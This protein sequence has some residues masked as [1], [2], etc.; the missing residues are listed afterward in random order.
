MDFWFV[1]LRGEED[2]LV[3]A[4]AV[5]GSPVAWFDTLHLY[6]F[7]AVDPRNAAS[8]VA[9]L[10]PVQG[11]AG[12]VVLSDQDP[13]AARERAISL[14]C[15]AGDG[16]LLFDGLARGRFDTELL[17]VRARGRKG[18]TLPVPAVA[19]APEKCRRTECRD[20]VAR[21]PV[22]VPLV[23]RARE[24]A[25]LAQ[26]L[27]SPAPVWLRAVEGSGAAR[28]VAEAARAAEKLVARVPERAMASEALLEAAIADAVGDW[29]YLDPVV[30]AHVDVVAAVASR[31]TRMRRLIL[32]SPPG[33]ELAFVPENRRM[34]L[35]R[36]KDFDAR[37]L[38][39][40]LLGDAAG[41][42]WSRRVARLGRGYPGRVIEAARAAVQLGEVVWDGERFRGRKVRVL[43]AR[44]A[45][46]EPL[47][48]RMQDVPARAMRALS[49]LATLGDGAP[50]LAGSAALRG[51][52]TSRPEELLGL[53][54]ALRLIEVRDAR[55]WIHASVRRMLPVSDP[56]ADTLL[57]KGVLP[58]AAE[59]EHL[60]SQGKVRD[61]GSLFVEAA[62][63]ALEAGLRAAAVRFIA[64]ALPHGGHEAVLSE[65]LLGAARSITRALGLAVVIEP[66]GGRSAGAMD[67]ATLEQAAAQCSERHD[68]AGAERLRVLAEVMRGNTQSALR[69]TGRHS[70]GGSSK[71]QL[72]AA[73]AQA[74]AGEMR[75]GIRTALS[76][77]SMSRKASD[78]GGEAAALA[79]LSSLYKACGRDDDARA[80]ADGARALQHAG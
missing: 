44:G 59:A 35:E 61:A 39:R 72:V 45:S 30:P 25:A 40:F 1:A 15:A 20:A 21:I 23:A 53:L 76:A 48:R 80:L 19:L 14:A 33:V 55:L 8:W 73:I 54:T 18:W 60:L 28:L 2:A 69:I 29:I 38:A 4:R 6:S 63:M 62:A 17:F 43:R 56:A 42:A 41:P 58:S 50:E 52:M 70:G 65:E 7:E 75:L 47:A 78:R 11:L 49:V 16:E 24:I 31:F 5:F 27:L 12:G 67:P 66:E 37:T 74:G 22:H 32:R 3:E 71:S 34:D 77:L 57:E 46:H 79:V 26:W 10:A 13:A 9:S 64:A 36:L 68:E 51:T